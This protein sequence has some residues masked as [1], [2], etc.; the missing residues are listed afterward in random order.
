MGNNQTSLG[1][2]VKSYNTVYY[3]QHHRNTCTLSRA[4]L[5]ATVEQGYQ[6]CTHT[7]PL[8]AVSKNLMYFHLVLPSGSLKSLKVGRERK[9]WVMRW[10][11]SRVQPMSLGWQALIQRTLTE[12]SYLDLKRTNSGD[13][14][15]ARWKDRRKRGESWESWQRKEEY[16]QSERCELPQF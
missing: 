11:G 1:L 14:K 4:I 8:K 13:G 5:N 12:T 2:V 6:G 16:T 7:T 9:V 10:T 15:E 3:N